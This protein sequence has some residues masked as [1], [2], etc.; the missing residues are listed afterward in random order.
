M[1]LD[2]TDRRVQQLA[3][4]GVLPKTEKGKY[5]LVGC[6]RGYVHYLRDITLGDTDSDGN[7]WR[8]RMVKANALKAEMELDQMKQDLVKVEKVERYLDK[9]FTAIKQHILLMPAKVSPMLAGEDTEEGIKLVL[10]GE[11]Q[12]IL[13]LIADYE[14]DDEAE[15]GEPDDS[16]PDSEITEQGEATEKANGNGVGE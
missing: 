12:D 7:K 16:L 8:E 9:L 2:L 11:A 13:T 1:M 6:V 5:D 3:K 4:K 14:I 15:D 10:E